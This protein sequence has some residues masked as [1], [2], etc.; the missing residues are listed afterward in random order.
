MT[1]PKKSFD[2]PITTPITDADGLASGPYQQW[3]D[4]VGKAL[5]KLRQAVNLM[6]D[7]DPSTATTNQIATAWEEFRAKLQEIV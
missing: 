1:A 6:D 4:Q 7:L 3:A 2:P 5:E